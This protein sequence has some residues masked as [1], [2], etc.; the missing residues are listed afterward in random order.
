MS[1]IVVF[2]ML[3]LI[4]DAILKS[5]SRRKLAFPGKQNQ[6]RNGKWISNDFL[7]S[8]PPNF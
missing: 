6:E 7:F 1:I 2:P 8:V 5:E 3:L 4:A